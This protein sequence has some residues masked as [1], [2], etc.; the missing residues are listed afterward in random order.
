[1]NKGSSS[2]DVGCIVLLGLVCVF[3]GIEVNAI[4]HHQ[5]G[6]FTV[7][8][9]QNLGWWIG[10]VALSGVAV[11]LILPRTNLTSALALSFAISLICLHVATLA[12]FPTVTG[13][14][15]TQILNGYASS[16]TL[17]PEHWEERTETYEC[18]TTKSPKTCTRTY[19]ERVPEQEFL[20]TNVGRI[21]IERGNYL[22]VRD[23]WGT[24]NEKVSRN[25]SAIWGYPNTGDM[26]KVFRIDYQG[27]P[28]SDLNT[29]VPVSVE[30][31]TVNYLKPAYA[32]F[33]TIAD[34]TV[35][36]Q[37]RI[38]E[39][40]AGPVKLP[41]IFEVGQITPGFIATAQFRLDAALALLLDWT[42]SHIPSMP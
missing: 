42:F 18:G 34:D 37:P 24:T 7:E 31:R 5:W 9:L 1:M 28:A 12:W 25:V 32:K 3:A 15:D 16:A 22:Y 35:P 40:G 10:L 19:E 38:T 39:T 21:G 13:T 33:G 27:D 41:R 30:A 17:I 36:P 2:A 23:L 20:E 8:A 6:C 26:D 11:A 29:I 4:I 14:G